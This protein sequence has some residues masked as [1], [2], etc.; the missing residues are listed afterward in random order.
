[1]PGILFA[2]LCGLKMVSSLKITAETA[3]LPLAPGSI[4]PIVAE[5]RVPSFK[6]KIVIVMQY[7]RKPGKWEKLC[8]AGDMRT[9]VEKLILV[10]SD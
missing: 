6:K 10:V 8:P 2:G 3:F 5:L 9:G 4:S 7:C 1:M